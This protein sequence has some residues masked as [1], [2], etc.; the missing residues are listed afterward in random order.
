MEDDSFLG[1]NWVYDFCKMSSSTTTIRPYIYC[2][3]GGKDS[4][5]TVTLTHPP[6]IV[7]HKVQEARAKLIRK[8][9]QAIK[10][11]I[12]IREV[13]S[14]ET[15]ENF[16]KHSLH[17]NLQDY[18]DQYIGRPI[19]TADKPLLDRF[20]K[21]VN[22]AYKNQLNIEVL[23]RKL[24]QAEVANA[25]PTEQGTSKTVKWLDI[26]HR[27]GVICPKNTVVSKQLPFYQWELKTRSQPWVRIEDN[28][29]VRMSEGLVRLVYNREVYSN[30]INIRT[31]IER[32]AYAAKRR[33]YRFH[34]TDREF[35]QRCY[36][37]AHRILRLT[38][39]HINR[40]GL[41]PG[42]SMRVFQDR[43]SR[44]PVHMD[45]DVESILTLCQHTFSK[46]AR[47]NSP[48]V[49]MVEFC[50]PTIHLNPA[51]LRRKLTQ[52]YSGQNITLDM[53]TDSS[54]GLSADPNTSSSKE[55]SNAAN[56][57]SDDDHTSSDEDDTSRDMVRRRFQTGI[58]DYDSIV[59]AAA[60]K[61]SIQG[62]L[63]VDKVRE[64]LR[65]NQV[66]SGGSSEELRTRL[67]AV[68]HERP[69]VLEGD[70]DFLDPMTSGSEDDSAS[71]EDDDSEIVSSEGSS[72]T[73][74]KTGDYDYAR[75]VEAAAGKSQTQGGL[76]KAD[77]QEILRLNEVDS[78]GNVDELRTRLTT[79]LQTNP[80]ASDDAGTSSDDT[81]TSSDDSDEDADT[82]SNSQDNALKTGDYDYDRIVAA[83]GGNSQ[84][85]GGL[86]KKDVQEILRLNE[87]DSSG[88]VDELRTRLTALLDERFVLESDPHV[89]DPM[90]SGSDDGSSSD[91]D[92][93]SS[94]DDGSSSDD[95]DSSSNDDGGFLDDD[96]DQNSEETKS[97]DYFNLEAKQ[98]YR[99]WDS[100]PQDKDYV[101][102]NGLTGPVEVRGGGYYRVY[103]PDGT[104]EQARGF[105]NI[106]RPNAV[107]QSYHPSINTNSIPSGELT[108]MLT[109]MSSDW[110]TSED[111]LNFAEDSANEFDEESL[112]FAESS[113]EHDTNGLAFAETSSGHDAS[114]MV[115]AESSD[116]M[117]SALEFA[118][119]SDFAMTSDSDRGQ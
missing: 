26:L 112:A 98:V 34:T 6:T 106:D 16:R 32:Q 28:M 27:N 118:E 38:T 82:S 109:N 21:G 71:G 53:N 119:S 108:A 11:E 75:L 73:T 8:I 114:E 12:L 58:Y 3:A 23:K 43:V 44:L 39:P 41:S 35:Q 40:V 45:M 36:G 2:D 51:A 95:D 17:A 68:L 89:L 115:F 87:V 80:L 88:N 29:D 72:E 42:L 81:D 94:D 19:D 83:A 100:P 56:S 64:I 105:K 37:V 65:L 99:K 77:V 14:N 116:K 31:V 55:D 86:N 46:S 30:V 63:N 66:E 85:Q 62:G 5:E 33:Q 113:S 54:V 78:S 84:T 49:Q 24:K 22:V 9:Q 92:D 102:I 25:T 70:L 52:I 59:K 69:T 103:R 18:I 110:A 67:A 20:V 57:S 13:D 74:L 1:K 79:L 97:A 101:R 93:S 10:D 96:V 104:F 47:R 7:N 4:M 91:D 61:T 107:K 90:T 15:K 76:N 48:F 50:E 117:S 60:G 111:E